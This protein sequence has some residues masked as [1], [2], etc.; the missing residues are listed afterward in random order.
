MKTVFKNVFYF[1]A[2][3]LLIIILFGFIDQLFIKSI[4]V[5]FAQGIAA[6][7]LLSNVLTIFYGIYV[8]ILTII[9]IKK[10]SINWP[11]IVGGLLAYMIVAKS[12][13]PALITIMILSISIPT[14]KNSKLH[15]DQT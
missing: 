13:L 12:L 6:K 15:A 9:Y 5:S 14:F 11:F 2:S 8:L 10:K 3:F 4:D 7:E 1:I